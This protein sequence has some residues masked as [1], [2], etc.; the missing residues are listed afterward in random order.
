MDLDGLEGFVFRKV[1]EE[2]DWEI[3]A[4]PSN[5]EPHDV[6][7]LCDCNPRV[8][9]NPVRKDFFVMHQTFG[10]GDAWV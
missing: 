3:H 7:G 6:F 10:R 5:G 2:C 1:C 8:L 4:I 9:Y